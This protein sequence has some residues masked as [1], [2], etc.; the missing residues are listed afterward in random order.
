MRKE[1][2]N[3]RLHELIHGLSKSDR[4]Y[5]KKYS[6]IF[7][8]QGDTKLKLFYILIEKMEAYSSEIL[9]K[10]LEKHGGF[11]RFKNT[12]HELY[13]QIL[14]DLVAL[15]SK[16]RPTWRYYKEHMKSGYLFLGNKFEESLKHYEVLYKIKEEATNVTID[17]LYYKYFYHTLS[18]VQ[19]S[20][21]YD[22]VEL[23]KK[24]ENELRQ[25]I[26]NIKTE[27]LLEAAV[28]NFDIIRLGS[29]HKTKKQF[30][31][32]LA[33]FKLEYVDVL[34]KTL[35]TDKFKMLSVYYF[36][37]CSY[38]LF[39]QDFILLS[40][41]SSEFYKK[42]NSRDIKGKF[43][44]EY[45]NAVYFRI[46]YLVLTKNEDAYELLHEYKEYIDKG[47]FFELKSFFYLMYR[48]LSLVT[49]NKFGANERIEKFAETELDAY[50]KETKHAKN[51]VVLSADLFWA[52][53]FTRLK[54]FKKAQPFLDKIFDSLGGIKEKFNKFLVT[55]RVLD[56]LIHFEL[57]NY[58]NI[59][60]Y[61]DNLENEMARNNQVI[62][63]DKDFFR[64]LRRLNQQLYSGKALEID[65]FKNF[66]INN[67][68]EDR[69][70]SYLTYIN[71]E[72][73]LESLKS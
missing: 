57:K 72:E 22:D 15:K 30:L 37:F 40:T 49:F 29:Y 21:N 13:Q 73:W 23:L 41:Y 2:E 42:Y 53:S 16:K 60:Y 54:Q 14:E 47:S 11:R 9:K 33:T 36:F 67:R 52:I 27:F 46:Q 10:K 45:S 61:I 59:K 5:L 51:R 18:F 56:I 66:L 28:H 8:A 62:Q 44:H 65:S 70:E 7:I 71:M 48:Q 55:A 1:I 20:R 32:D 39:T 17:Y 4:A 64:Y 50:L 38:A 31:K 43:H 35:E 25:S 19:N 68:E 58:E 12:E 6:K 34:P 26:E 24:T 3:N 63:F 69:I